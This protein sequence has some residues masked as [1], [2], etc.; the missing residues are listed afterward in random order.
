MSNAATPVNAW[1]FLGED[2]PKGSSYKTPGSSYQNA[3]VNGV[4]AYVD[5]L[6]ICWV[7]TVS[8]DDGGFS[9]ALQSFTHPDGST[10]L[11][12]M[13][14]LIADARAA[15]P[16]IKVVAMMGYGGNEI[17][18]L[19]AG[20]QSGWQQ[21]ADTYAQNIVAYLQL[22]GLDGL[23]VDWEPD[24]SSDT[25]QDQF[26][27]A[28]T[29]IGKAFKALPTPLILAMGPSTA[30]N[31]DAGTVNAWF[32]F[33][34]L[35]VYG[36]AWPG[37]FTGIG[38]DQSLLY[39]GAKFEPDGGVPYQDAPAAYQQMVSGG[40]HGVT[41]WRLNSND[42]QY[43]QAQQMILYQMVKGVAGP[44]F[45]DGPIVAAAGNPP[46]GTLVVRH[47][48][49]V[50]ALQATNPGSVFGNP[51]TYQLVQ[52]GG[53]G[54]EAATVTLAEG[55]AIASITGFTGI[56]YGWECVLQIT[57]HT[58]NGATFGPFGT[59][60]GAT[61][62]TPF[63]L[64]AP[65]GQSIVAFSGSTVTVPEAGGGDSAILASLDIVCG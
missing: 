20:P 28:F 58:Q 7:N 5:I 26:A 33:L 62:Q 2:D 54:G 1:I 29:A 39:Y 14:W 8:T 34:S 17:S 35:Q 59:M 42:F 41:Q 38:I 4:Y 46:I 12:Y 57:V 65:A 24:F 36:G 44:D 23:D 9:I 6:S 50:D 31:L 10:N 21:V 52:H 64:A 22:Y 18:Q 27:M 40:Y 49:V 15:N 25:S 53:D 43:E 51:V 30:D 55:D 3:V 37:S 16:A 45:D 63:A 56:W 47:G 32:D 19:F 48:D 11:D 61:S 13:Q 60:A